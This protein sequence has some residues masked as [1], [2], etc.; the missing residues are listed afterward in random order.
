MTPE[1][2]THA[3]SSRTWCALLR[4]TAPYAPWRA[5]YTPLHSLM[6]TSHTLTHPLHTPYTPLTHPLRTLTGPLAARLSQGVAVRMVLRHG[7]PQRDPLRLQG[8]PQAAAPLELRADAAVGGGK[9]ERT[10]QHAATML[11]PCCNHRPG[12]C[13]PLHPGCNPT[14]PHGSRWVTASRTCNMCMCTHMHMCMHMDMHM[15]MRMCMYVHTGG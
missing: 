9:A 15:C 10:P 14:P 8:L 12:G 13:H 5:P 7:M 4:L 11:Q 6:R 1:A 2:G 3:L